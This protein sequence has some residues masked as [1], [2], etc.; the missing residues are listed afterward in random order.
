MVTIY[1][2]VSEKMFEKLYGQRRQTHSDGNSSNGLSAKWSKKYKPDK[3]LPINNEKS[4]YTLELQIGFL[5]LL[6]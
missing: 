4:T 1:R 6:L 2:V 5:W 3:I